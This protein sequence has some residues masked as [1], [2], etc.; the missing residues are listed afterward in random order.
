MIAIIA[1]S[2]RGCGSGRHKLNIR[3]LLRVFQTLASN[4]VLPN[5][6]WMNIPSAC[7]GGLLG[8]GGMGRVAGFPFSIVPDGNNDPAQG[9]RRS[10]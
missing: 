5:G 2:F 7:I 10:L 1:S 4:C 8:P 9:P 3:L 6:L